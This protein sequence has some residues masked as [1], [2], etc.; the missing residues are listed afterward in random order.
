MCYLHKYTH[1]YLCK[2][3]AGGEGL[4][5][6]LGKKSEPTSLEI[7]SVMQRVRQILVRYLSAKAIK[8]C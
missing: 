6:F 3:E 2:L 7:G 1:R 5:R 4:R 8:T